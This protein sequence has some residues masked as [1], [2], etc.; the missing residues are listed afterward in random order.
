MDELTKANMR[1][2]ID[3]CRRLAQMTTDPSIA[4]ELNGMADQ[5]EADLKRLLREPNAS[6]ENW[7]EQ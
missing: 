1:T 6:I 3:R 2:R 7:T 5:G 4:V